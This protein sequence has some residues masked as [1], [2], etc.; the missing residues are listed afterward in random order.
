[1]TDLE[2]MIE[3]LENSQIIFELTEFSGRWGTELL[4][5]QG[6]VGLCTSLN[7]CNVSGKLLSIEVGER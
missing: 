7:F 6:Y 2:T 1:M 5:A 3:M 4:I